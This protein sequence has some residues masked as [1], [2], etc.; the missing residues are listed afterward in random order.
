MK[1][2]FIY[3]P[4][5]EKHTPFGILLAGVS[6]CDESYFIERPKSPCFCMEYVISGTGT[7]IIDKKEYH[8]IAG[9]IYLLPQGKDHLYFSDKKN[10]WT[11]IWFNAE[12]S[13]LNALASAY[14]PG[15]RVVFNVGG[16]YE[17]FKKIHSIGKNTELS[18]EEKHNAA[19]VVFHKLMQFLYNASQKNTISAE[20]ETVKNYI[21]S[22]INENISIKSL[23]ELVYLSESQIIRIFKSNFG[24]TPYD[25]I[26]DL[27]I[28][29]AKKLLLNTNMLIKEIAF[30]LSFCDEHYFSDLFKRKTGKT[31]SAF[32]RESKLL[33]KAK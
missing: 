4:K 25:Y 23:A 31:P 29:N 8:P 17:Y 6:Y 5:K 18:A 30:N 2:E 13:L 11:K 24:K 19:A 26:L 1:E 22:H 14:N 7:V 20:A 15:G 16:G 21:D 32:K 3:F 12:G 28:E 27:K 9:D 33:Y 10:P